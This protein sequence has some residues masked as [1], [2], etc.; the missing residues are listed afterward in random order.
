MHVPKRDVNDG[1]DARE[2]ALFVYGV[3]AG[4]Y[5]IGDGDGDGDGKSDGEG[6]DDKGCAAPVFFVIMPWGITQSNI[7]PS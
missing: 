3:A 1:D 7:P 5:G 6:A 4:M 2:K